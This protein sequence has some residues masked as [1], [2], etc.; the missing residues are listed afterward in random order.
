MREKTYRA[1][2]ELF[3]IVPGGTIG[4]CIMKFIN[5][6]VVL[7][8]L[9]VLAGC[10]ENGGTSVADSSKYDYKARGCYEPMDLDA[11]HDGELSKAEAVH[12]YT[13]EFYWF[14]QDDD[15]VIATQEIICTPEEKLLI[16][17]DGNGSVTENEYVKY[18]SEHPCKCGE[19]T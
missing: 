8:A 2:K 6:I 1:M 17:A 13:E 18:W 4:G 19:Y 14:D 7:F 15:G 16:D 3:L 5:G 11:N 12:F 10:S 9:L